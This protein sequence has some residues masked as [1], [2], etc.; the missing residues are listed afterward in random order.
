MKSTK[1]YSTAGIVTTL[2]IASVA[3]SADTPKLAAPV[4]KGAV[5]AILANGVKAKPA[6][7]GSFSGVKGLNCEG[8]T[9]NDTS[10]GPWCFLTRD[11]ID[12]VK[13]YYDKAVGPMRTI[14]GTLVKDS[15]AKVK[16]YEVKVERAWFSG[17]EAS[18]ADYYYSAVSLHALPPPGVPGKETK[19]SDDSWEGQEAYKFFAGT[20]F[21]CFMDAVSWFGEPGKRD[22]SELKAYYQKHKNVESAFFQRKGAKQEPIDE[23]LRAKY[24]SK[25]GQSQQTNMGMMPGQGQMSQEQMM[26][27]ARMGQSSSGSGGTP[28]DKEFNAF[29]KKNPKVANRYVELTRKVGSLMQQGKFDEADAAD[30]ELQNLINANPELAAIERRAD[31]GAA[32]ANAA[33][34]ARENQNMANSQGGMSNGVWNMCQEYIKEIEKESYYT[35]IVIDNALAGYQ[36]DYTKDQS[37]LNKNSK[38]FIDHSLIWGF[39]YP[40]QSTQSTQSNKPDI[41]KTQSEPQPEEKPDAQEQVQDAVEDAIGKGLKSLKGLF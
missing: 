20:R 16:G 9:G 23:T 40:Q 35:L 25:R 34:M 14:S 7:I 10:Y 39:R 11:P 15:S 24:D 37:V 27:M 36:K 28:D 30:E 18:G 3:W 22:P 21:S 31:E 29:M 4:Y 13:A 12:K 38:G 17:G 32:R 1:K 41:G 26:Q 6:D 5:P 2:F 19:K 8:S 33:G